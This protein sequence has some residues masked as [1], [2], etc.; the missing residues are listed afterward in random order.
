MYSFANSLLLS[1]GVN[2][3]S[4]SSVSS[5]M[6]WSMSLS[7][8]PGPISSSESASG[9]GSRSRRFEAGLD[10]F[11][12]FSGRRGLLSGWEGR[13]RLVPGKGSDILAWGEKLLDSK[14]EKIADQSRAT[15]TLAAELLK[16][17]L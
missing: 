16:S 14:K 13:F 7:I 3:L 17:E 12:D 1:S 15:T 4:L 9:E 5:S 2:S 11:W 8:P 10:F 6:S